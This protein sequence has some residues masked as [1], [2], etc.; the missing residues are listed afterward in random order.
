MTVGPALSMLRGMDITLDL[1]RSTTSV[2]T[3]R[4]AR[5]NALRAGYLLIGVGL[6]VTK[7][8]LLLRDPASIPVMD[9][10]VLAMLTAM[11]L[12]AFLGLRYPLR[13]LPILL[14][15]CA[16]KLIWLAMVGLPH[17]I[18]GDVSAEIGRTL[19]SVSLVAVVIAVIPWDYVWRQFVTAPG[20]PWR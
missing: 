18:A 9:G 13:M 2:P 12:L 5:L 16:W 14:F 1:P 19:F 8:P 15:E 20:D 17:L 6:A 10:V 4:T 11:S 7:W 3:L